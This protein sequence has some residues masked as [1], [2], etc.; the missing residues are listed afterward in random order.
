MARRRE[1]RTTVILST[2]VFVGVVGSIIYVAL[3][4]SSTDDETDQREIDTVQHR[5]AHAVNTAANAAR[6]VLNANSNIKEA[7]GVALTAYAEAVGVTWR[8]NAYGHVNTE[9]FPYHIRC[10]IGNDV[11]TLSIN[12]GV[13]QVK[14]EHYF[15]KTGFSSQGGSKSASATAVLKIGGKEGESL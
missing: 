10:K 1:L 14:A 6:D 2:L 11:V 12:T 3:R 4:K 15:S 7:S 9:A 8:P 5:L 13:V